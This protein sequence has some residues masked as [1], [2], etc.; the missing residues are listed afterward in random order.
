MRKGVTAP[1][2]YVKEKDTPER[3]GTSWCANHVAFAVHNGRWCL[4]FISS[5]HMTIKPVDE[6]ESVTLEPHGATFCAACDAPQMWWP[7]EDPTYGPS[8]D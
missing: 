7:C 6:I 5:G 2:L 1:L 4:T 3:R 8:E